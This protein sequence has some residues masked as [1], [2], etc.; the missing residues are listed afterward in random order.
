MGKRVILP[1]VN[2]KPFIDGLEAVAVYGATAKSRIS[3]FI[4]ETA[5]PSRD[6]FSE[7]ENTEIQKLLKLAVRNA[8]QIL[9]D[10]TTLEAGF[11]N[12][13]IEDMNL[14]CLK[15]RVAERTK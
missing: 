1:S 13:D 9:D 4:R 8:Q 7:A 12:P 6:E 14:G 3:R 11:S 15:Q 5:I 2:D 10:V